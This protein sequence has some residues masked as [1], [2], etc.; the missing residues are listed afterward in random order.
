LHSLALL[1]GNRLYL[2]K[3]LQGS[4]ADKGKRGWITA[5]HLPWPVKAMN[6]LSN[7]YIPY[8]ADD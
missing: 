4:R 7:Y 3:D 5:Y 6:S 2:A 8:F 1:R